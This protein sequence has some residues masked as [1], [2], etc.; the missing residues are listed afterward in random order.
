VTAGGLGRLPVAPG[1]W[2]SLGAAAVHVA[3]VLGAGPMPAAVALPVLALAATIASV[4]LCG[5]AERH[6]GATDPKPFVV[7]EL[8]G[9]WLTAA[10]LPAA[11]VP[12]ANP[13]WTVPLAFALFRLFDI[14]KPP[15]VRRAEKLGRGFGI[16][17]DDLLAG[18]YAAACAWVVL[19]L[20]L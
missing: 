12:L 3:L 17:A 5:W 11:A 9:Y 15:P 7:D 19:Q 18:L 2:G 8:A 16:V 20:V 14:A 13:L 4:R 6:Y 1:T 10:L